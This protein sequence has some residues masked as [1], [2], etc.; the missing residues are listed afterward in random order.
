[1]ESIHLPVMCV[2]KHS[3][4]NV[5]GR[6]IN[7]HI[8]DNVHTRVMFVI[9]HSVGGMFAEHINAYV[10]SQAFSHKSKMKVSQS[11]HSG[12]CPYACDVY[13]KYRNSACRFS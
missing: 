3:L 4:T 9:N 6:Y 10:E 11:V 1:M 5:I 8:L 7:A 13:S 12:A 2:I